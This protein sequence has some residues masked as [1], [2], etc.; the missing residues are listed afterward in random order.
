MISRRRSRRLSRSLRAMEGEDR[1]QGRGRARP[2]WTLLDWALESRRHVSWI[3]EMVRDG[4]I[5]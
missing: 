1:R 5:L 3:G 2:F 4:R